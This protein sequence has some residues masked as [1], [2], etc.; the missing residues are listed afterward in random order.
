L[1]ARE[2]IGNLLERVEVAVL[3]DV[4]QATPTK[5]MTKPAIQISQVMLSLEQ[6]AGELSISSLDDEYL[7]IIH[8]KKKLAFLIFL[9]HFFILC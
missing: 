2:H 1:N 7:W 6:A 4:G 9:K 5:R 8:I 3:E